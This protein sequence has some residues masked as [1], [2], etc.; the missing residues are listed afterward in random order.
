[1]QVPKGAPPYV[2]FYVSVD[3]LE[4]YLERAEELGGKPLVGPMPIGELG[5]FA[6]FMD[7]DGLVV[8]LFKES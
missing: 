3:D 6:L 2:T 4:E 5:A 1:M 7:L 8:G